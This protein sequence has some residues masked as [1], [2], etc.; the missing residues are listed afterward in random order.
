MTSLD[1]LKKIKSYFG[2]GNIYINNKKNT[3]SY[4][5][6]DFFS[7]WHIIILHFYNYPLT[8]A[9][10]KSFIIFA[11]ILVLLYPLYRKKKSNLV[12]SYIVNR[13]WNM[14]SA[15]HRTLIDKE[16]YITKNQLNQYD[17]NLFSLK[18]TQ[19]FTKNIEKIRRN[20]NLHLKPLDLLNNYFILGVIEGDG[21]FYVSL[22][23]NKKIRFGFNIGTHINE[24]DLLYAIKRY[25]DCGVVENKVTWCR[26]IVEGNNDLRNRLMVLVDPVGLSGSKSINY[27]VFQKVMNLYINKEHQ[28]P[29]GF[30]KI[31]NLVYSLNEGKKRK[32]TIKEYLEI[33][34]KEKE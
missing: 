11:E 15:S 4:A 14:N 19:T 3:C 17:R 34:L 9:K 21:S 16:T 25:L 10:H 27:D 33:A 12:L 18:E 32:L 31:A 22:R 1:L 13:I 2:C 5:V 28:T 26:Y 24:I 30:L 20:L 6:T 29:T 23:L 7:L 8:S